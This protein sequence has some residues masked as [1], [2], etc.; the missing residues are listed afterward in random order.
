MAVVMKAI[1]LMR[2][3]KVLEIADYL[4]CNGEELWSEL[5]KLSPIGDDDRSAETK[6][7]FVKYLMSHPEQRFWQAVRNFSEYSFIVGSNV[8]PEMM[9]DSGA[10]MEDT[11]YK[12]GK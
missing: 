3:D 7:E 12:E 8:T 2:K 10:V 4:G 9:S 1:T 6:K 11:F 5:S